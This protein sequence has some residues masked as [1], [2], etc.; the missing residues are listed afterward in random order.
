MVT[1]LNK[2]ANVCFFQKDE[3]GNIETAP[4]GTAI[5]RVV[6]NQEYDFF[7]IPHLPEVGLSNA[8]H[9]HVLFDD[10]EMEGNVLIQ[11]AY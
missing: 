3:K 6:T 10:T 8:M 1:M 9:Y 4:P 2:K 7:L 5:T 11:M